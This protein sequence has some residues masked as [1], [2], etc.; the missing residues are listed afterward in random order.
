MKI[1]LISNPTHPVSLETFADKHGLE[2]ACR[3]REVFLKGHRDWSASFDWV[4]VKDGILL[5]SEYGVG[6][7]PHEAICD[8]AKLI[9]NK[10][11]IFHAMDPKKRKEFVAPTLIY[12]PRSRS[13]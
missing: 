11:L 10:P 13:K 6:N 1:K 8:Y 4:E 9:S 7:T 12:K 3:A 2:I 5:R